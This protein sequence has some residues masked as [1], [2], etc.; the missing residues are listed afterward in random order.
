MNET[1][2]QQA[3][4]AIETYAANQ[5]EGASAGQ[6]V[7][8]TY[9]YVLKQLRAKDMFAAKRGVVELMSAL[10]M[11]Q[12]DAAGPLFR[13]YEYLLD[14][15]RKEQFDEALELVGELR[16]TWQR[17]IEDFESQ[18]LESVGATEA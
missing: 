6:L 7:L 12:L 15:I 2:R 18:N 8:I 13:M 10:N 4:E 1:T 5:V 3:H 17:V 16:G 9:D 11:D 14:I